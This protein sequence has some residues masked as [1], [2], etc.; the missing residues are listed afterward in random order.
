VRAAGAE[1]GFPLS[2]HADSRALRALVAESGAKYIY[3]GP[4]H[5]RRFEAF[6]RRTGLGVTR[7]A[8]ARQSSQLDL[9]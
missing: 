1:I 4:R 9:F 2:S 3:L 7:F 8:G 5:T 6:L